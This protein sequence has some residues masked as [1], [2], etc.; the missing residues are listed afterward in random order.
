MALKMLISLR[1]RD[2]D[3][4][5][6]D[7]R[8]MIGHTVVLIKSWVATG[9][10]MKNQPHRHGAH[11][12]F[13]TESDGLFF[14]HHTTSH[15]FDILPQHTVGSLVAT[16]RHDMLLYV[17][18]VSCG[19]G[20]YSSI[21]QNIQCC[22]QYS[23]CTVPWLILYCISLASLATRSDDVRKVSHSFLMWLLAISSKYL[24]TIVAS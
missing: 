16:L 12:T 18:T 11:I 15:L 14:S 24:C 8:I 7:L 1:E 22:T 5:N 20:D 9:C 4:S 21:V 23:V 19:T 2:T 6:F 10:D 3:K 17:V 13:C